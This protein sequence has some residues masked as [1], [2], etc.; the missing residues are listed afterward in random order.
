M[1]EQAEIILKLKDS[2]SP[3]LRALGDELERAAKEEEA[4]QKAAKELEDQLKQTGMSA[5]QA[6]EKAR[7]LAQRMR[8]GSA[9]AGEAKDRFGDV[10]DTGAKLAGVLGMVSPELG[11]M[12]SGLGDLTDFG[13][14]AAMAGE[15]LGLS[16]GS[17]LTI[18][19]PVAVA[20]GIAALAYKELSKQ[21]EEADKKLEAARKQLEKTQ[22]AVAS[23]KTAD[24]QLQDMLDLASGKTSEEALAAR[25]ARQRYLDQAQ[26]LIDDANARAKSATDEAIDLRKRISASEA[27][28]AR[29][30][31]RKEEGALVSPAIKDEERA[32][33]SLQAQLAATEAQERTLKDQAE[34][35]VATTN[36]RAN[37]VQRMTYQSAAAA[38]AEKNQ[39]DAATEAKN[40]AADLA[41]QQAFLAQVNDIAASS[42][43]GYEKALYDAEKQKAGL[44]AKAQELGISLTDLEPAIAAINAR[45][46]EAKSAELFAQELAKVRH[47][48]DSGAAFLT[49]F[50]DEL[51]AMVPQKPLSDLD[52]LV[53][54]E[55]DLVLAFSRG[56]ISAEEYTSALQKLNETRNALT[57][58]APSGWDKLSAGATSA[59][60]A[61]AGA[62]GAVSS[63]VSGLSAAGPIGAFIA[64]IIGA[65]TSIVPEAGQEGLLDGIHKT[66]MEF[67]GDLGEL[68]PIL[69]D[70]ITRSI[71]E[72]LPALTEAVP[73]LVN[74]LIEQFPKILGSAIAAIPL[75]VG[76]FIEWFVVG[77]PKLVVTFIQ[78]LADPETWREIGRQIVEGFRS[79]LGPD[80]TGLTGKRVV[81]AVLTG[82]I[83]EV[84]RGLS[85]G[86]H[87]SG[88]GRVPEN[89][90][91][92]LHAGERVLTQQQAGKSYGGSTIIN[93]SGVV[94]DDMDALARRLKSIL[95]P[96]FGT[97]A[98]LS[99]RGV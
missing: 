67:F 58:K 45:L 42:L 7:E 4:T 10:G 1:A 31:Q 97:G 36:D 23:K 59:A 88:L 76:Q 91:Y 46:A 99:Y 35:L 11:E 86:S 77:I 2:A 55:T 83:S 38:G 27:E 28:L 92:A 51:A 47:E 29:L 96:S 84:V 81:G 57:E 26:P 62:V 13:E 40:A 19:G 41:Q 3:E 66:M 74:G 37:A 12:A 16:M 21:A 89:G 17:L 5:E 82:G 71:Q 73:A 22:A 24:Q 72:G 53:L 68:A 64:A 18:L 63:G 65:V 25:D 90:L 95:D 61:G 34:E 33:A 15:S 60:T 78:T 93:L 75:L 30:S 39:K 20:I 9:S 98:S 32:L 80:E 49:R 14:G 54:K 50:Q 70:A 6:G 8:E 87:D 48:A 56:T 43:T 94:A 52:R 79:G 85:K 44:I 69:A